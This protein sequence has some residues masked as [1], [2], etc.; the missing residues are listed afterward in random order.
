MGTV[1]PLPTH[2]PAGAGRS[3]ARPPALRVALATGDPATDTPLGVVSL[4]VR[5][6]GGR[7]PVRLLLSVNGE[8]VESWSEPVGR[9]DLSLD[10][11]GPGR[12]VVRARAVDG[13]GRR[14]SAS[15]VVAFAALG[16]AG[17][18]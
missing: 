4:E 7:L 12:H 2:R 18:E 11:Y 6:T 10:E 13:R 5:V 15:M 8:L 1:I 17:N 16:L 3:G 9:C 14:A